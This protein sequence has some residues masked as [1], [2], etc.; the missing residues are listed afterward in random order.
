MLKVIILFILISGI[1]PVNAATADEDM[2]SSLICP[3][4][5]AMVISTCDC[6][7]AIQIKK[8]ISSMKENGF[9]EKQI[10]S[11]LQSEYGKEI[12][13]NPEKDNSMSLWMGGISLAFIFVFLGFILTKKPNPEVI[14]HKE[15]Y[16]KRF[17]EDYQKFVSEVEEK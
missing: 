15:K 8:E 9:S 2:T 4:V 12:L 14:P 6:P 3:C 17:E 7:T 16:E 11:A 13:A 1:V 10:F 5:C